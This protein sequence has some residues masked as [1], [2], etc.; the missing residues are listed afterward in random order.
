MSDVDV[1]KTFKGE[2]LAYVRIIQ[3]VFLK[4]FLQ[5]NTKRLEDAFRDLDSIF[6]FEILEHGFTIELLT[7]RTCKEILLLSNLADMRKNNGACVVEHPGIIVLHSHLE[8]VLAVPFFGFLFSCFLLDL[9]ETNFVRLL[10]INCRLGL[11]LATDE[12]SEQTEMEFGLLL[13]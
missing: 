13:F 8:I 4:H 9:C 3:V 7:L 5:G 1:K 12:L 10:R 11:H 6:F 2:S